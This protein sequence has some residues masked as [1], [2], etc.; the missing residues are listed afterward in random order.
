MSHSYRRS[1]VNNWETT[2]AEETN[3]PEAAAAEVVEIE[4]ETEEGE[5][6]G[7]PPPPSS[8]GL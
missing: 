2:A 7:G 5:A 8:D 1:R 4:F 3:S 6:N